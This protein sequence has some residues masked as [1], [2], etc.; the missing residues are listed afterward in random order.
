[1]LKAVG[2]CQ[3]ILLDEIAV[4]CYTLNNTKE[5]KQSTLDDTWSTKDKKKTFAIPVSDFFWRILKMRQ[6]KKLKLPYKKHMVALAFYVVVTR[7]KWVNN[8][9]LIW[10]Q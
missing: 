10:I 3:Y 9:Y 5:V 2:I 4:V 6:H 8:L 7:L 1:M